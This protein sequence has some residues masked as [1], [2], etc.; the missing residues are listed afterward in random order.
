MSCNLSKS[1]GSAD[2][3]RLQLRSAALFANIF[4]IILAYYQVKPASRSLLIEFGGAQW[5][6]YAWIYSAFTLIALIGFYHHLVARYS[7]AA[8]VFSSLLLF[9]GLLIVFRS[10]LDQNSTVAAIAFYILVDIFSV[11]LVEQ[12]WSLTNSISNTAEG[13]RTYWFVST[14][15]LVGGV[16]GG[17]IASLIIAHTALTTPDLL[18]VCSGILCLTFCLNVLMWRANMYEEV[19]LD[20]AAPAPSTDWRALFA[21]RYLLLIAA[22]LCLSQLAQPIIEYQ[23]IESV[24]RANLSLDE[25]TGYFGNFFFIMGL[26]SI[27]VNL[28]LTPLIHRHL[29]I[30]AGLMVQPLLISISSFGFFLHSTLQIAEVMKITDRG[31]SYSINRAS[32]ELLY[33]PVDPVQTY[34]AKAWIDM[35]GYRLFKVLGSGIILLATQWLPVSLDIGELSILTFIVCFGW[36]VCIGLVSRSYQRLVPA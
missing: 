7:R 22:L 21:N 14:G 10:F 20:P 17:K 4:L 28:L 19:A 11:V 34:Q 16:V 5:F 26:I 18:Y 25:K 1:N 32:K 13:R 33:I 29:G 31:L 30:F 23:F 8:I 35:L 6:P 27:G 36:L 2:L 15:G 24:E 9:A 12:F 3:R